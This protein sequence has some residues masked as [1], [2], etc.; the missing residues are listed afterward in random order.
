MYL[1]PHS[2]NSLTSLVFFGSQHSD[3]F[4]FKFYMDVYM[5]VRQYLGKRHRIMNSIVFLLVSRRWVEG[6]GHLCLL[7]FKF[8]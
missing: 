4:W 8:S 3:M 7:Y 5:C 2:D 1:E 6:S